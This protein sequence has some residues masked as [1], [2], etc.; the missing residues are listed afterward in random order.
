MSICCRHA[1]VEDRPAIEQFIRRAYQEL[2]PF[3][4]QDRWRWQFVENPFLP[5]I[6]EFVPV[7]IALDG[8]NI[9]GQIAVQATDVRVAGRVHSAGWMVDV[10]ILPAYRGRGI[11]HLLHEA[12]MHDV[13]ILLTLTMA[14]A[15]RRMAERAGA[16]TLGPTRQFSRWGRLQGDDVQRFLTRRTTHRKH[17]Q[18]IVQLACGSS[19]LNH[20]IA[21]LINSW[22][23]L[24]DRTYRSTPRSYSIAEVERFGPEID[25]LWQRVAAGYPAI[26]PR[27]SRFLNWRFVECPQLRYRIFHAYRDGVLVGYSVLRRTASQELRHGVIVDLFGNC[28]DPAVFRDLIC[29]AVEHFGHEVASVE[30]ATSLL[31]I[32]SVFSECGFFKTRTLKPTVVVSDELLRSDIR[33]LRNEWFFSKGDHDWD[34]IRLD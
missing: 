32:E 6:K 34:Q 25:D 12:V 24:R 23:N 19:A 21:L 28:R 15:T 14:P 29:H 20:V 26:C 9:V 7:W 1:R 16:I 8:D 31:E 27:N 3:K 33:D 13:P 5:N 2:A 11:G 18:K 30:C 22:L 10:M 17:L 4:G